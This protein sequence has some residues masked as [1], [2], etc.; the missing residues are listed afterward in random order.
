MDTIALQNDRLLVRALPEQGALALTDKQTGVTFRQANSGMQF[1]RLSCTAKEMAF[2]LAR[3]GAIVAQCLLTLGD[4]FAQ[5]DMEG[6]GELETL[7][8]PAPWRAQEQ[9]LCLYPIG[10]GICFGAGDGSPALPEWLD[11][12]HGAL[13]SMAMWGAKRGKSVLFSVLAHCT[14]ARLHTLRRDGLTESGVVWLGQ[15]G[16]WGYKR[17]MRFYLSGSIAEGCAHVRRWREELGYVRTLREKMAHTPELEKLLGAAD[18]WLWDDNNMNRLY[19]RPEQP[20]KTPRDVRRI[21]S[22]MKALGME[23]VL[24]NSFEGETPEDCRF[25][26]S[27]GY[28]VGKYDIYR[29]VIPADV[30]DRVIPYRLARGAHHFKNWPDDVRIGRDGKMWNAWQLH[31][32]DGSMCYQHSICDMCALKMTMEDVPPDVG[33]VGYNSRF[34]DVQGGFSGSECWHPLH[35]CTRED[36]RRYI[37]QQTQFLADMGLVAGVEAGQEGAVRA[38]H[39]S[40]G[41]ISPMIFRAEDAGRRMTTLYYGEDVPDSIAHGML[42]AAVRIPLWELVYHDCAVNYW[43]WGDNSN[44][45]PEWMPVRDLFDALYGYPPLYSVSASQWEDLKEQIAA[46]YHRATATARKVALLPMTG[47]DWLTE[48][49][50]VQR[51]V[52]GGKILVTANFSGTAY[53]LED[54]EILPPGEWRMQEVGE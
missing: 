37:C 12:V 40:E 6:Q 49:R 48:D 26:K 53:A 28:L 3:E 44:C 36:S 35:P 24:W 16:K 20:E 10:T 42:N 18:V 23:R 4:A 17:T 13:L 9:D 34:I 50:L 19:A 25:L 38:Y 47:F 11:M 8:F 15:K 22:E 7:P 46:S 54:G 14:D 32:T 33:R 52:F 41:T 27:L 45:C 29:D 43:Y 21:A 39:F 1:L 51:S 30:R 2:A 5:L 31:T